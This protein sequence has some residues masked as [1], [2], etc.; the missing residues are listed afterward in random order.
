MTDEFQFSSK[1]TRPLRLAAR[2]GELSGFRRAVLGRL[3][4][5]VDVA[6]GE[7]SQR[8]VSLLFLGK[9]RLEQLYGLFEAKFR[10]P[11]LQRAVTGDLVILDCLRRCKEPGIE[12]GRALELLHD[13][14]TFLDNAHDGIASFA[15]RR[16]VNLLENFLKPG[17]VLFGLGLCRRPRD[18]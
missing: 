10:S 3:G 18:A 5:M 14:L 6:L 4:V 2:T 17:H 13:I 16:F 15:P 7:L 11:G 1:Q 9:R 12:R 8:L